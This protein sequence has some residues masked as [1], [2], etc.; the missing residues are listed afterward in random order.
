M[1]SEL[2]GVGAVL[3]F[4]AAVLGGWITN[5][6]WTFQQ[7]EVVPAALGILGVVV[8]PIGAIHGVWLWF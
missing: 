5:V 7:T 2:W 1:N 4:F 8:A 3:G 6:I